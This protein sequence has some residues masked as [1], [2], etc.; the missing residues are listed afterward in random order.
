MLQINRLENVA[1]ELQLN[2]C[3]NIL[4]LN[5]FNSLLELWPINGPE[6]G[7]FPTHTTGRESECIGSVNRSA[8]KKSPV[9][10]Q[11]YL[12]GSFFQTLHSDTTIF[13]RKS[14]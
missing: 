8:L 7:Q 2:K 5:E 11:L 1:L 10:S 12:L 4:L 3:D 9:G 14:K 6:K 13:L